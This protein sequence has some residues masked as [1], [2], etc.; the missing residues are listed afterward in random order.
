M[1]NYIDNA[2]I[3][4]VDI[5]DQ[6]RLGRVVGGGVR[7][8]M[9][10]KDGGNTVH[11]SGF[12]G[13]AA[14]SWHLQSDN[15][16][17]DLVAR[18][19]KT[20]ARIE[21]VNDFNG[22]VGGPIVKDKLWYFGSGRYQSTFLQIPNTF[23]TD[24]SPGVE[25]ADI[26]SFVVR[27]TWQAT[28]RNKFAA[29]YQRNYKWK[30]HEISSGGQTGLPVIPDIS[31][32]AARPA[33]V[34]HRTGE[35]DVADHQQAARRGRVLD[36]HPA[37]FEPLRARDCVS[38]AERA[39]WFATAT[40]L[41]TTTSLRTV[42]GQ[43]NQWFYPNQDSAVGVADLRHRIAH[44]QDGHAV[45]IRVQ[46]LRQRHERRLVAELSECR[47]RSQI[48]VSVTVFNIAAQ[49]V[50]GVEGERRALRPGPVGVQASSRS[51]TA[52]ATST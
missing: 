19:L 40:H 42:A 6:R 27:G 45:G 9:I 41:N 47:E 37:L 28:P 7:V 1:Q 51:T 50:S 52:F 21:H 24:G 38:S 18:G 16:T 17:P 44:H 8:N 22:A 46:R 34:L 10:P 13:G 20:G 14:D 11:G 32:D 49:H 15:L 23:N 39:A 26:K 43:Y 29:T 33:P 2:L 12:F 30:G 31:A 35:V 25:D 5:S 48:P 4:E 3:A 36:R